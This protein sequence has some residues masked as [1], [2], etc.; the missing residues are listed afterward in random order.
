VKQSYNDHLCQELDEMLQVVAQP[1]Y[2]HDVVDAIRTWPNSR[3]LGR[4]SPSTVLAALMHLR[5][6]RRVL[7]VYYGNGRPRQWVA[8]GVTR[9]CR[10]IGRQESK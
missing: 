7:V 9:H 4:A 5:G 1:M 6:I 10:A 3:R 2:L 8:R